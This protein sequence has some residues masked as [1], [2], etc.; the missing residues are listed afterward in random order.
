MSDVTILLLLLRFVIE[1]RLC[2]HGYQAVIVTRQLVNVY[3]TFKF[4]HYNGLDGPGF[5]FRQGH[6]HCLFSR[7]AGTVLGPIRWVLGFFPGDKAAG[8]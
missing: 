6:R 5:E 1:S 2:L 7:T 4:Q 3:S 8:P